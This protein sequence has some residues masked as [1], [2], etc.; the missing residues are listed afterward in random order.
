M[1]LFSFNLYNFEDE[2]DLTYS[3]ELE[4]THHPFERK[5]YQTLIYPR[6]TEEGKKQDLRIF[7]HIFL[8]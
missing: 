1:F 7:P 4:E 8:R 2:G 5:L 6:D 3:E